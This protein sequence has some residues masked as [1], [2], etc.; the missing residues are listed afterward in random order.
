MIH[1]YECRL[2]M[3]MIGAI[4]RDR[5]NDDGTMVACKGSP[6][7]GESGMGIAFAGPGRE[8]E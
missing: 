6:D 7:R 4:Y 2:L 5:R 1:A 8:R 3:S